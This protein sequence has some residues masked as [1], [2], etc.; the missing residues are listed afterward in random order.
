[1]HVDRLIK[2]VNVF[3]SFLKKFIKADVAVCGDRVLYVGT[4]SI[5]QF[6]ASETMD[7]NG[8]YLIP[9]LIDIHLHIESSMVTPSTFSYGLIKNGVTT[10]IPEPHEMAN[11]FGLKGVQAMIRA[12]ESCT[13]DMFYAI[14]SSVPATSLETNGGDIDIKAIDELIQS[15]KVRCLGEVMNYVDVISKP[16]AKISRIIHHIKTHYPEM[17]IEGHVPKL[18]DL[19]LSRVVYAG[20]NSDHTLQ[21]VKGLKER[22]KQG[23]FVE[24]QE[25]SM[26]E[27]VMHYLIDHDEFKEHFCFVTDDVMMDSFA[28]TGHLNHLVKKAIQMGM[29]PE[30]AIYA[31]TYAPAQRMK[32]SD[33]GAIS[34]GRFADF[35]LLSSLKAFTIASVFK[36]GKRVYDAEYSAADHPHSGQ[37]PQAFYQSVKLAPLSEKDFNV[38]LSYPDGRY[39][40]RIMDVKDGTTFTEE[41]FDTLMIRNEQ[42]DWASSPY[43]LISVFERYGKNGNKGFGL[44]SGDTIKEGAIATTYSHDNHDLMVIGHN[45]SDM[46]RAANAV[47]RHQGGICVVRDGRVLSMLAL[48][49][50]GIL[51]E[52]PF[53]EAGQAVAQLRSTMKQ[54]GYVHY[55]PIMSLCT[56]SLAV[57][58]ALKITDFGLIDVNKGKVVPL[59]VAPVK[60]KKKI[61]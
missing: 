29:R 4:E 49:L 44:V 30:D 16:N 58:P 46:T 26:S 43:A 6:D 8:G 52:L 12:S 27:E 1:M 9:G 54:L 47:I 23:V 7:G 10:I 22:F 34:P 36:K 59:V 40:C 25:K 56:H 50:G 17:I 45:T 51:T 35:V 31:S 20:V 18:L 33:R 3:N 53:E 28:Q 2:H 42:L 57:S 48:P 19:D 38:R 37:F 41:T 11:V 15:G 21:T 5:D 61:K 32:L 39:R 55:N 24:I 60:G 14:P 13:A